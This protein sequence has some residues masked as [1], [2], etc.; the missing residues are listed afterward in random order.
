VPPYASRKRAANFANLPPILSFVGD[1]EPF[2]DEAI[3]Y[4]L[5]FDWNTLFKKDRLGIN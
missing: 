4:M 3:M 2:R 1:I 5:L